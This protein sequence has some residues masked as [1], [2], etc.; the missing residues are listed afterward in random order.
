MIRGIYT[1][2]SGMVAGQ[3]RMDVAAHNTAN[4]QTPGYK[5]QSVRFAPFLDMALVR[6]P[7]GQ[8]QGAISGIGSINLGAKL[9]A[10]ITDFSEGPLQ[11]SGRDKDIAL[12]GKGFLVVAEPEG[13]EIFYTRAGSLAVDAEGVLITASG[14][15]LLGENGRI[16]VHDPSRLVFE[17]DG[18]VLADGELIDRLRIAFFDDESVLQRSG[19]GLFRLPE[20]ES[21]SSESGRVHVRQHYLENSNVDLAQEMADI[22]VAART[23]AANQ[24]VVTTHD[25]LLEKVV[26]QIGLVR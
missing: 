3:H 23:Y 21:E 13:E 12:D 17:P 16:E 9:D 25:S 14:H 8:A 2:A 22:I 4:V 7:D 15:Y 1:S 5:R 11:Y 19:E 20:G 6:L 24:R 26:N 18:R 10:L